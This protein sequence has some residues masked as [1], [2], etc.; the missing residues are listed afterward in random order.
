MPL[1]VG[2]SV[3][4]ACGK[5]GNEERRYSSKDICISCMSLIKKGKA[6]ELVSGIK[7]IRVFLHYYAFRSDWLNSSIHSLLSAANNKYAS[8]SEQGVIR[9]VSGNNG[10]W[11][12]VP[13]SIFEAI[14]QVAITMDDKIR[15]MEKAKDDIPKIINDQMNVER[16]VIYNRGVE[17]GRNLLVQL[18][19]GGITLEDLN[20]NY[21][22]NQNSQS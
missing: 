1:Y 13:D 8:Y 4:P 14:K 19:T 6:E 16:D 7:Y 10:V 3:C 5:P 15:D 22:Y 12:T 2:P 20:K 17:F 21:S 9:H 11:Y 18:N